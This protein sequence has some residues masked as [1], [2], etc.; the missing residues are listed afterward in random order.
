[1]AQIEALVGLATKWQ[2]NWVLTEK[3][4]I[5]IQFYYN[6]TDLYLII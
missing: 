4:Y 1:M 2:F 5:K 6:V 3:N